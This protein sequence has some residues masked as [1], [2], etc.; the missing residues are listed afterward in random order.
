LGLWF[1]GLLSSS[2]VDRSRGLRRG[3]SRGAILLTQNNYRC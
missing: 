2:F 1:R 3:G